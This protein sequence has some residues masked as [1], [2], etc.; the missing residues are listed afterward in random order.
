MAVCN[1]TNITHNSR[2]VWDSPASKDSVDNIS[3]KSAPFAGT[4]VKQAYD[5]V[6]LSKS[7]EDACSLRALLLDVKKNASWVRSDGALLGVVSTYRDELC[8]IVGISCDCADK[9]DPSNASCK[10]DNLI[11]AKKECTAPKV[12]K[13]C[14]CSSVKTTPVTITKVSGCIDPKASNY[15]CKGRKAD[16]S[17]L[18]G[19]NND[20]LPENMN[21]IMCDYEMDLD[22]KY[23]YILSEL[24]SPDPEVGVNKWTPDD[25]IS[26]KGSR[27]FEGDEKPTW[28]E[29]LAKYK[30]WV[31]GLCSNISDT[32]INFSTE[33]G[34]YINQGDKEIQSDLVNALL[35]FSSDQVGFDMSN[36][37]LD[38]L[39]THRLMIMNNTE[40]SGDNLGIVSLHNEGLTLDVR[41]VYNGNLRDRIILRYR[42]SKNDGSKIS[43]KAKVG[44]EPTA[45]DFRK[46]FKKANLSASIDDELTIT[47]KKETKKESI[48]GLGTLLEIKD[49]PSIGL[50][51][52]LNN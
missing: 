46:F 44:F 3:I 47:L 16:N 34:L 8:K 9:L 25:Y 52:L 14:K 27:Q 17:F 49:K 51:S 43:T 24:N 22:L 23:T 31:A 21:F 39:K 2:P 6:L 48:V 20:T 10:D 4:T 35:K 33:K 42:L 38:F 1:C 19:P 45:D 7:K 18:C 30:N 41:Q 40:D 32:A 29:S 37:S 36:K 12:W 28:F 5:D 50:G 13:N 11:K 15:Y 26:I